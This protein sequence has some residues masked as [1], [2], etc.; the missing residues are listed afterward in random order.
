MRILANENVPG[1]A[2]DALRIRGH[3]VVWIR[4]DA[5]G[6]SD[7][8]ILARAQT[9]SRILVTFD[10]DF[11]QLAFQARLPAGCGIVLFR[12]SL[13]SPAIA[14]RRILS[15]LESRADWAGHFATV[16]DHRIR[17]NPLP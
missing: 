12:L 16:D 5:P 17:L 8:D 10:K 15:A 9:E 7:P 1:D 4:T 2:V 13:P 6:S 11:G 14:A 3:D